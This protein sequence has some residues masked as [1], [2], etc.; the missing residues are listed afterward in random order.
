MTLHF[1]NDVANDAESTQ[2]IVSYIIRARLK[3]KTM[4]TLIN[5]IPG[6]RLLI[7]SLPASALRMHVESD[8]A[9]LAMSTCVLKALPGK[10]DIKT[11]T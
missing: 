3:I 7:S 5:R 1:W 11:L 4:D 8:S 9:S 2:K 6:S 10:L